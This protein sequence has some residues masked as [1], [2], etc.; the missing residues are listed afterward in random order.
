MEEVEG[1]T[2]DCANYARG[3]FCEVL[4]AFYTEWS[5]YGNCSDTCGNVAVKTRTRNCTDLIGSP[6]S[7]CNGENT[8]KTVGFYF[9][10]L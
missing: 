1:A 2:C 10:D 6:R 9:E 3:D 4:D 7:G 5:P 8:Q